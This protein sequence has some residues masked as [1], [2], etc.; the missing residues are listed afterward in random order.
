MSI[1]GS[2]Y[3]PG[4]A[5][6]PLAPY[7]Q[8]GNEPTDATI[9]KQAFPGSTGPY[10]LYRM[11]YKYTDCGPSVGFEVEAEAESEDGLGPYSW[12]WLTA[13]RKWIFCDDLAPLGSWDDCDEAA[14]TFTGMS[15]GSIVEGC[16][17]GCETLADTMEG[18]PEAIAKR[19]AEMVETVNAEASYIWQQTHGCDDCNTEG[20]WGH[21]AIDPNCPA[22]KGEGGII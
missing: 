6:D 8:A 1:F 3:P 16:D 14:L 12:G 10:D 5:N 4:A 7:N 18:E 20:E 15:V 17:F 2:S 19:F 9:L 22:C 13:A 11:I 21:P